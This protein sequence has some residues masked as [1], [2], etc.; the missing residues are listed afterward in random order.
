[1]A[2]L[3]TM[4][5]NTYT[6]LSSKVSNDVKSELASLERKL[7]VCRYVY[8]LIG[9][10]LTDSG[11]PKSGSPLQK[12]SYDTYLA[13]FGEKDYKG[14]TLYNARMEYGLANGESELDDNEKVTSEAQVH[15]NTRTYL[16]RIRTAIREYVDPAMCA[17][18]T[19]PP[20]KKAKKK[21][22]DKEHK[23]QAKI[24]ADPEFAAKERAK[25][26]RI[27][28][29]ERLVKEFDSSL[30]DVQ[31]H[32]ASIEKGSK[33]A[34]K[35]HRDKISDENISTLAAFTKALEDVSGVFTGRL[36]TRKTPSRKKEPKKRSKK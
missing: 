22:S 16:K 30:L 28:L 10:K 9:G 15:R 11:F 33:E 24:A 32:I 27:E 23:R 36:V 31:G 26:E 1:M 18:P 6:E 17:W 25:A 2:T 34:M 35:G 19:R 20:S 21:K 8:T 3:H 7:E 14:N 13:I 29:V 4:N 5:R 12:I